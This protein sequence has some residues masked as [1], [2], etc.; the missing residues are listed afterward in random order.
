MAMNRLQRDQILGRALD[1][2]DSAVLDTKDRPAGTIL[3]TALS[4]TWLQEAVDY[5]AKKWPW[6]QM[7]L[8][9]TWSIAANANTMVFSK[10]GGTVPND[11]IL[12][13]RDGLV[14]DSLPGST[15]PTTN[16][17]R[18]RKR[19]LFKILELPDSSR[20]RPHLYTIINNKIIVW[21]RANIGYTGTLYYYSLPPVLGSTDIP[22]FPD[23]SILVDYVWIKG[24]EYHRTKEVGSAMAYADKVIKELQIAGIG[25][26]AEDDQ[27]GM[28]SDYAQ[29]KP[30]D[31][32]NWMGRPT[33]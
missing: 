24:Q 30:V 20:D 9:D 2:L 19:S 17:F 28:D 18:L 21:P 27:L 16:E 10:G 15:S 7:V 8:T 13:Y 25:N 22:L 14:I 3:T 29:E 11:Y 26:E 4:I 1:R 5:F 31:P 12:D 6:S 32:Y 33:L 23:D